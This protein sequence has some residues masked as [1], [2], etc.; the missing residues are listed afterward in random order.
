[1]REHKRDGLVVRTGAC[2]SLPAD[3]RSSIWCR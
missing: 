3:Y 2:S 1:M